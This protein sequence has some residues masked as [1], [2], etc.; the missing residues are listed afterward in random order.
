MEDFEKSVQLNSETPSQKEELPPQP[1]HIQK[2]SSLNSKIKGIFETAKERFS[3]LVEYKGLKVKEYFGKLN[4]EEFDKL[5]TFDIQNQLEDNSL[6]EN[7]FS[8]EVELA[9]IRCL[10]KDQKREAIDKFKE[11]LA[12]QREALANCRVFIE[13]CIEFNHD[14]PREKLVG[15]IEKFRAQYGFTD[16]QKQIAE[17]LIDGYYANRKKVLE[18]R[19]RLPENRDLVNRL[20]GINFDKTSEFDI[21]TG[22]MSIDISCDG[23]D[24]GRIFQNSKEVLVSL[25][26]GGFAA[27]SQQEDV[28]FI[29]L[30]KSKLSR[31]S[32]WENPKY[33]LPHEQEHQKNRLFRGVFD[34]QADPLQENSI[35]LEY[36]LEQDPQLKQGLLESYFRLKRRQAFQDAKDEIIAMK[37]DKRTHTYEIFLRQDGSAYDYLSYIRDWEDKKSDLG[38]HEMS[39]KILVEEYR[40]TIESAVESFDNLVKQGDYTRE[41]VIAMFAD[42]SLPEWP[43]TTRRLLEQKERINNFL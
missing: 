39:Q 21:S 38:W 30:N 24:A 31:W 34:K 3:A 9:R 43:K 11:N 20:T 14:V 29:I 25:P 37:K 1:T 42:K 33:V 17:Q 15:I 36:E 7:V 41:E 10:P 32:S 16:E 23:F 19:E 12:M 26:Y 22:P 8:P 40:N 5:L 18:M 28:M 4:E 13:R 2:G 35:F 6:I 27:K